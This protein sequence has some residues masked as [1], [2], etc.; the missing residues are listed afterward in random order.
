ME[1]VLK[2]SLSVRPLPTQKKIDSQLSLGGIKSTNLLRTLHGTVSSTNHT[3]D[4]VAVV[5]DIVASSEPQVAAQKLHTILS[6]FRHGYSQHPLGLDGSL[7]ATGSMTSS[8]IVEGVS[9][10]MK[11]IRKRNPLVH[12]VCSL[13]PL[14]EV[15]SVMDSELDHKYGGRNAVRQCHVGHWG[16]SNYGHRT[17][18]NG[19][20][21]ADLW[22]TFDQHWDHESGEP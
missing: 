17:Q 14:F 12:Q 15:L 5:S 1:Q 13:F 21:D 19:G 7:L 22:C 18:R 8:S 4:G 6:Q 11:E 16:Q 20:L 10:L 3:L 2:P 9:S